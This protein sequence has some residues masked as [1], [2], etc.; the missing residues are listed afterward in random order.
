MLQSSLD[1][2]NVKDFADI[3]IYMLRKELKNTTGGCRWLF[4]LKLR[5]RRNNKYI[6]GFTFI[7]EKCFP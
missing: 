6:V 4:V 5:K 2:N 1:E 3:Q 7:I